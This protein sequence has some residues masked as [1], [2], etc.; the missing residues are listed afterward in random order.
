MTLVLHKKSPLGIKDQ[1]KRQIRIMVDTGELSAGQA[2]FSARDMAKTLNV[3]RNTVL[4][5]YRE[6]VTEGILETVVGSGTFIKERKGQREMDS[7]KKIVDE[8]FEKAVY[9]GFSPE[10]ITDFVLHRVTTYFPGTEGGRVLVVECNQEALEDISATL[11]R[12]LSV[13]TTNMLIQDL[14]SDPQDATRQLSNIDLIVCGFN[15]MEELKKVVPSP[16]VEVVAVLLK[17]EIRIMNEL[18]QLPSG[19]IVGFTCATQRSTETFYREAILSGGSTLIKIWAGLNQ[20]PELQMLLEKCQVIFASHYVYDR[21]IHMTDASRRVIKVELTI[22]QGNINF[23]RER[24]TL[25]RRLRRE[26]DSHIVRTKN[27]RSGLS[28]LRNPNALSQSGSD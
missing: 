19:A 8:A 27:V 22:D 18:M 4:A 25:A 26:S 21:I 9:T 23:I 16:P 20:G 24:L 3:N 2:L 1:I 12:D 5:A 13:H 6:L 28:V 7:L 15:H 17:P 11:R 10:Q 14:E